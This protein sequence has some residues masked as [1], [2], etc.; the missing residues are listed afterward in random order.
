MIA[1]PFDQTLATTD[2]TPHAYNA[3]AISRNQC[4]VG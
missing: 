2:F 4:G 3:A 1:G